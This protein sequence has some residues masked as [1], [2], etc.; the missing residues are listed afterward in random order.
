MT[1]AMRHGLIAPILES[2]EYCFASILLQTDDLLFAL[3][4]GTQQ[5]DHINLHLDTLRFL[6]TLRSPW[7]HRLSEALLRSWEQPGR[8][9]ADDRC[10]LEAAGR[11]GLETFSRHVE[12]LHLPQI[13]SVRQRLC[14]AAQ[15]GR[16][17]VPPPDG[18]DPAQLAHALACSLAAYE[19]P[20]SINALVIRLLDQLLAPALGDFYQEVDDLLASHRLLPLRDESLIH[21][22]EAT[23][24]LDRTA[25]IAHLD[26]LQ[27][28]MRDKPGIC[29][30]LWSQGLPPL[31]DGCTVPTELKRPMELMGALV[32]DTLTRDEVKPKARDTLACLY[33][34]L[35]KAALLDSM[36]ISNAHHPARRLW[37]ELGKR[38]AEADASEEAR[39]TGLVHE[40][41]RRFE[42]DLGAFQA[43]LGKLRTPQPPPGAS[44]PSVI[45]AASQ[46]SPS[47]V[48]SS[49]S[50]PPTG[51]AEA[52]EA[53]T[54]SI[55]QALAGRR[56]PDGART[57]LLRTWGP[58]LLNLA[59]AEGIHA[60]SFHQ[61]C[62]LMH[63]LARQ[64]ALPISAKTGIQE[65][66][67]TMHAMLE[68]RQ[69]HPLEG[70]HAIARVRE[71]IQA[72]AEAPIHAAS[73]PTTPLPLT[74]DSAAHIPADA[75]DTFLRTTL[76]PGDWFLVH[77]GPEQGPRRLK[78]F[79][80]DVRQGM[81][82]LADRL[83]R[84]VLD[85]PLHGF[86]D[87][88]LADRSRP[89]FDDERHIFALN[90]LRQQIEK[91]G[92][93]DVYSSV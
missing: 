25:L 50:Q 6:R 89:V 40:F 73:S 2:L 16:N 4:G 43:T 26:R 37:Q 10:E 8:P 38:L 78:V 20:Q 53:T 60:A 81:V 19:G 3:A 47:P 18:L 7:P 48:A 14:R 63:T 51:F 76:Q 59:Q 46:P 79:H 35:L 88:M 93:R 54:E 66:L 87:D 28:D 71:E 77:L 23:G 29:Q 92:F 65:T 82:V 1:K 84:P 85:R 90:L 45:P 36:V 68:A 70:A 80:V 39:I 5:G 27:A 32:Y 42:H 11:Q 13:E 12:A 31:P 56:L 64:T 55:R 67:N 72:L 49:G 33:I 30:T 52:R 34:P 69:L 91:E 24:E 15:E 57:F 21:D 86:I 9:G 41:V 83:D 44:R 17:D 62:R 75:L 74:N 58:L 61:A 22:P